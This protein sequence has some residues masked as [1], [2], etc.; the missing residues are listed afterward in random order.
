MKLCDECGCFE[1]DTG[2]YCPICGKRLKWLRRK[3]AN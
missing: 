2:D 1:D 3:R